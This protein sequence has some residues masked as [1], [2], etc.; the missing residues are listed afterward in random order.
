MQRQRQ[1]VARRRSPLCLAF[2][3][4][5]RRV[6]RRRRRRRAH[7]RAAAAASGDLEGTTVT[8]FGPEVE[9]R[10]P[11]PPG[12]LRRSSPRRPASRSST[13]ATAASRPRSASGSTAATRRTSP[14]SRSRARSSDFPRTMSPL[15]DDVAS[16][17]EDNFDPRL[18]R[19][20]S[21]STVSCTGIPAKADL[22]SLVWYSPDAFAESGY[23]VPTTFE[24]FLALA[25]KMIADG[26]TPFCIGIGSDEATGW[27]FTDWVE[28]F[29]LPHEGPRGLRPVGQRTRSRSTTPT[30]SRSAQAVYD[31]WSKDGDGLRRGRRASPPRRSPTPACRC[32]RATA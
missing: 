14:C 17:V 24:D 4:G 10:G 29:M 28:D 8:I 12:R 6:R 26:K 22:K 23:E 13:R 25:D 2:R 31:L 30:S 3:P 7:R 18:R 15:P 16:E 27:P 21:R 5:R 11:G 1:A 32:S 9:S 20:A 19:P